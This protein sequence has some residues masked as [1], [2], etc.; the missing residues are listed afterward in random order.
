LTDRSILRYVVCDH[1]VEAQVDDPALCKALVGMF[2]AYEAVADR[3]LTA[4]PPA[5]RVRQ[6]VDGHVV[7]PR[8][9][10]PLFCGDIG[11]LIAGYEHAV[12]EALLAACPELI[13]LHASGAVVRGQ[14]LLILGPSGAGKSSIAFALSHAG[15]ASLGDDIVLLDSDGAARP[16]KRLFKI[17]P[18]LLESVGVQPEE[19]PFWTPDNHEAWY[20]P[21]R[22]GGWAGPAPVSVIVLV[23]HRAKGELQ[24]SEVDPPPLL[25]TLMHSLMNSG[26][27]R[28]RAFDV[29]ADVAERARRLDVVFSS[30]VEAPEAILQWV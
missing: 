4:A 25:N 5:V 6:R 9:N 7:E 20:D 19:T 27:D 23:R 29:L 1:V 16:F 12:T 30:A 18:A 28:A 14:A 26:L 8:D 10:D 17:A 24:V 21:R 2:P 13:H 11:S 22:Y 3:L 15:H